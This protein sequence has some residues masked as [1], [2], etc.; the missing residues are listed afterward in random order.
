MEKTKTTTEAGK[1]TKI[2]AIQMQAVIG[3]KCANYKKVDDIASKI[4]DVDVI[5]L[6]EVWT[7]GWDCKIFQKNA[8]ELDKSETL[9]FLS[10]LAK[11]KN[12]NII[13]GSF[14]TKKND[15]YYNTCPVINRQ[16]KLITTYDKNHLYSYYGS[17]EGSYLK[18]GEHPVLVNIDGINYGLTIC[19]DIRFPE[20]YRAYRKAG[21]QIFINCAAWASTKPIPWE[22]MTKSRAIENQTYMV[23]VNQFGEFIN[24]ETNLGHSR[25]IDYNG[26]VISEI[27]DGEGFIKAELNIEPMNEFRGKCTILK[28]IK[29]SYEVLKCK[30]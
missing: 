1:K 23:A 16:G 17:G 7:I 27:L 8:E 4:A 22:M 24:N 9:R 5:V 10:N 30:K 6:P 26:N 2:A 25:I 21:A 3:D 18:E 11:E 15:K 19:Y 28:D 14:I 29:T 20:I 12:C 13:G